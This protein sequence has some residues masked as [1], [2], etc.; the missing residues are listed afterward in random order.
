MTLTK[1]YL[2]EQLESFFCVVLAF[3]SGSWLWYVNVS[4]Y[5][6]PGF[7]GTKTLLTVG[8]LFAGVYY[9]FAKTYQAFLVGLTRFRELMFGQTLSFLFADGIL[10]GATFFW[11]HNFERLNWRYYL[12]AYAAQIFLSAVYTFLI[13]RLYAFFVAPPKTIVLYGG[14]DISVLKDKFLHHE[15]RFDIVRYLPESCGWEEIERAIA[16]VD[17]VY[18]YETD[19]KL[20]N[21][22]VLYCNLHKKE[23][24][25]SLDIEDILIMG[26]DVSHSLDTPFVRSKRI[27][28]AWY[29]SGVKRLM[30][31]LISLCGLVIL[32]PICL[33]TALLIY[34]EDRGPVIYS[35]KR[36]TRD[37]KVFSIH[38][39]RSMRVDAE[40]KGGAQLA[41]KDDD[42][43]T[44]VGKT[45]RAF[46]IDEIPQL[47]NVI[48][49]DMTLVGP[50]PERPEMY[51]L[52]RKEL[53]EF[54]MRMQVKAGLTGYAQV[55]GKYNTSPE[56]KLKLD[57]LY[58][59]KRSLLTDF[60]LLF[61]T[62]KIFIKKESAE[63]V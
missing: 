1:R 40:K 32:S 24:H 31:I 42:R 52:Y 11:F 4:S 8:V 39:F 51:E 48:A 60:K 43:I 53:P 14:S 58:I 57:L 30:D 46:R 29:Y 20:R 41:R 26:F 2:F 37:G 34:L 55:F 49:G 63:G 9:F 25:A 18:L 27:P 33:L 13:N 35:Q 6:T 28:A 61:Y 10:Y 44:A 15:R 50:R 62:A 54:D 3:F 45:I 22:V 12:M 19:D 38:K 36:L 7:D 56:D 47:F 21:K 5:W 17:S 23:V 16:A 59:N